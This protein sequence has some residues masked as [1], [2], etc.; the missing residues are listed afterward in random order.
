MRHLLDL[1]LDKPSELAWQPQQGNQ[2]VDQVEH[3][4]HWLVD[5][6]VAEAERRSCGDLV[7]VN[8]IVESHKLDS[9]CF[10]PD[11]SL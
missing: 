3:H 10:R 11:M 7:V 9:G 6:L 2:A 4:S 1:A 8:V 5:N